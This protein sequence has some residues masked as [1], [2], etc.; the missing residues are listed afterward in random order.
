MAWWSR[1]K[2]APAPAP[3][4]Q[5]KSTRGYDSAYDGAR[6]SGWNAT[7]ASA[8]SEVAGGL[9]NLRKRSRDLVRNAPYGKKGKESAVSALLGVQLRPSVPRSKNEAK[10]LDLYRRWAKRCYAHT[11]LGMGGV[12]HVLADSWVESGE[13]LA[14]KVFRRSA[15]MPGLPPFQIQILEA[16]HLDHT[17]NRAAFEGKNAIVQGVEFNS[18]GEPVAYHLYRNHPGESTI[19]AFG[20]SEIVRVPTA[21][22]LHLYRETR[23]GQVRGVPFSHAVIMAVWDLDGYNDANRVRAKASACL[24]ASVE[25]GSEDESEEN[26]DGLGATETSNG[27]LVTDSRGRPI[28]K[29]STGQVLYPP[30]DK[31]I[32]WHSPGAAEAHEET[33]RVALREI[34]AGYDLAYETLSAD[35]SKTNFSSIKFGLNN[36]RLHYKG[37]R[38]LFFVPL[39]LDVIWTWFIDDSIAAGLLPRDPT[40]YDVEWSEP[41]YG[42]ADRGNEV[43]AANASMRAGLSS[44]QQ[45]AARLGSDTDVIDMQTAEDKARRAKLGIVLDSDPGQTSG[46]GMAQASKTAG[47]DGVD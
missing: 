47:G 2:A 42:S 39:A 15:D 18:D 6:Q 16:D 23:P 5:A 35:L 24:I 32:N 28:E 10:A 27:T 40:L 29:L 13:V 46:A 44:R 21:E 37:L 41:E 4:R 30:G 26:P 38:Q 20:S 9:G 17:I 19:Y 31:A 7:S 22:I 33:N 14:R 3:K 36:E 12:Q 8:N 34:A 25:G 1:K 45:E 11:R 43:K